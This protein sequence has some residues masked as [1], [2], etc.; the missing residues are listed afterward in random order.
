MTTIIYSSQKKTQARKRKDTSVTTKRVTIPE[1]RITIYK[2]NANSPTLGADIGYA[3]AQN[4]KRERNASRRRT[5][6]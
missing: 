3:F 1:G 6:R 2:V 4:V 5:S